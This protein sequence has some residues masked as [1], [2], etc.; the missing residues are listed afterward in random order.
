MEGIAAV[1]LVVESA[2]AVGLRCP[3]VRNLDGAGRFVGSPLALTTFVVFSVG[4]TAGGPLGGRATRRFEVSACR[5]FSPATLWRMP[6]RLAG[7]LGSRSF[8]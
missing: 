3:E 6:A 1:A 7:T 2:D 8:E 4:V 5:L